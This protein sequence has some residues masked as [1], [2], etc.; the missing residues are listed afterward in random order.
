MNQSVMVRAFPRPGRLLGPCLWTLGAVLLAASWARSQQEAAEWQQPV[1]DKVRL[2][3]LDAALTL[4]DQRLQQDA[5][6]LEAHGWRGRLLA[7]QGQW[8]AAESEYRQVLDRAPNDLEILCGLADV[9]LWQGKFKEALAIIDPARE[10]DPSEPEILLRRARILRALRKTSQA[11]D[12]YRELLSAHPENLDARNDLAGL[13]T[14][15]RHE[16]RIG[17]D[18]SS[19]NYIGP[20]EDGMLFLTS[21]W[22]PRFTTIFKT[23]FYQRFGQDASNFE[24][25]SS[26]RITASDWLTAGGAFASHQSIIPEHET[27]FEYG[28]G[29]RF[30]NP[31]VKGLEASYQ[32]HW[33]WYQGGHV[34]TLSSTQLYYLPKEWT[35]LISVTGARSGFA[36]TGIEWVPSGYT[37]LG[38]PLC[39]S[40]TGNVT[41]AN[42][43]EDFALIDQI[44][45]FSAR[46]FAGGLKYRLTWN[47]D[48]TGS[49]AVQRRSDGETQNSFGVSYGFHF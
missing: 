37:R 22:T 20:A 46:T 45:R 9:L 39:R 30:S 38:F 18:A 31:W 32:Q 21:R 25:S 16:L 3:Q 28:H 26:F 12:Q 40:L 49:V 19:F 8:P 47:Q 33:F 1:R 42:G 17:A 36:G 2:H 6:D 5:S 14:E 48:I 4:V 13:A 29:L 11:S 34:L 23:G 27:F 24:G 35:W 43:T 41:F 44:G 15:N 10:L 7:W